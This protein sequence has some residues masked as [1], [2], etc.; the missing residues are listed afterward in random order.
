VV[1]R[2]VVID[3]SVT[4]PWLFPDE[5]SAHSRRLFAAV[6]KGE[7][8]AAVP[9]LWHYEL[10]N[11]LRMAVRRGRLKEAE[12]A[13]AALRLELIPVESVPAQDQGHRSVLSAALDY[14]LTGHDAAFFA[15]ARS[16]GVQLVTGDD[17]LLRLRPRFPWIVSLED[18]CAQLDQA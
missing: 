16:R 1:S 10:I 5:E 17:D 15:L 2:E 3:P 14:D 11:A 9:E 7:V 13:G 12:A 18:F 4:A 8:S 6:L